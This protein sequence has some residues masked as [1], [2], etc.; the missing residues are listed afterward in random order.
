MLQESEQIFIAKAQ[1]EAML[2]VTRVG[3]ALKRFRSA[4]GA[5]PDTLAY[6]I[7]EFLDTL[8]EDPFSGNS[9]QY[10]KEG[11]AFLLYSVG[12]DLE[13]N[14]GAQFNPKFPSTPYDIVWKAI[15]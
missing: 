1:N 2:Q 13:D 15:R 6:L 5:Y 14:Q 11:E 7:P 9:L 8:P 4:N 12:R 10:R 3:L